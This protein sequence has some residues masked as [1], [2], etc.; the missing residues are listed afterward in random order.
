MLAWA[1][2]TTSQRL[3]SAR[4]PWRCLNGQSVARQVLRYPTERRAVHKSAPQLGCDDGQHALRGPVL[5]C[6]SSAPSGE[7]SDGSYGE[8][9]GQ[10]GL[11][12]FH[13]ILYRVFFVVG[14]KVLA[15]GPSLKEDER[16][17]L[18]IVG[19]DSVFQA[20]GVFSAQGLQPNECFVKHRFLPPLCDEHWH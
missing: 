1:R 2:V 18:L 16:I 13:E 3:A 11:H 20:S 4:A 5:P 6:A 10:Q 7:R 14:L 15:A 8:R 9:Y 17:W 19:E 12:P